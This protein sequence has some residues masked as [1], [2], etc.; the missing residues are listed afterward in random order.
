MADL[1]LVDLRCEM[2]SVLLL[3]KSTIACHFHHIDIHATPETSSIS[4]VNEKDSMS[5]TE[6]QKHLKC[7]DL[8]HVAKERLCL[9]FDLTTQ[10][11]ANGCQ[12]YE[13][14]AGCQLEEGICE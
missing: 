9:T 14:Y 13:D 4:V 12:M 5:S 10:I 6:A 1:I 2:P 11:E 3:E 8:Q 7:H